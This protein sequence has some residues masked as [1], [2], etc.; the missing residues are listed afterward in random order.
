M[1]FG[2]ELFYESDSCNLVY[3]HKKVREK[4]KENPLDPLQLMINEN[5]QT[6]Q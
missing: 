4:T 3:M 2:Q 5:R 1:S 6:H